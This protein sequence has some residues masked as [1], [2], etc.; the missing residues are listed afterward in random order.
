MNAEESN[1]FKIL[2]SLRLLVKEQ[3]EL[4]VALKADV[5]RFTDELELRG[6]KT[7]P[8]TTDRDTIY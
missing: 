1:Q 8:K 2:S 4:I 3:A 6:I 5:R 7:I